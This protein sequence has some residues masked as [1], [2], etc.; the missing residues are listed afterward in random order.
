MKVIVNESISE[1]EIKKSKFI[2]HTKPVYSEEE[3]KEFIKTISKEHRKATHNVP[4]YLIGKKFEIQ[5]YSD[6]G[7]PTG[8][9]GLPVLRMLMNEEVT[10]IVIVITRYF[11]GIKLGKG[12]LLRAYTSSAKL[13]LEHSNIKEVMK[14]SRIVFDLDYSIQAKFLH[15]LQ[16]KFTYYEDMI[17]YLDL[18]RYS[19]FLHQE[20]LESFNEF[21]KDLT[22]GSF[23][24]IEQREL[25]GILLDGKIREVTWKEK[26]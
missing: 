15:E 23:N 2:C 22:L 12:G 1:L 21:M 19:Y 17:E 14:L 13:G 16:S 18:I 5:K 26:F 10:N 4:I 9:A 8:T 7:E 3:A 11:G 24:L 20:D 25:S 6:D